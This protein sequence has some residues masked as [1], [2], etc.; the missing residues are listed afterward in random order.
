[1]ASRN[2]FTDGLC[3]IFVA[4]DTYESVA[5]TVHVNGNVFSG[6]DW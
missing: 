2:T 3:G 5:T 6:C 4:S 1:M